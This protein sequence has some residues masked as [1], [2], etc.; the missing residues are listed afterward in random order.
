MDLSFSD[1][2]AMLM[3]A[4][5]TFLERECPA[6][7]VRALQEDGGR[8][9]ASTLWRHLADD[10][11]LG[12]AFPEDVGG[13]GGTLADLGLFYEA[14]GRVLLP[15]AFAATIH[16]GLVVEALGT[17]EQRAEHLGAIATGRCVAAV[18][19]AELEAHHDPAHYRTRAQRHDGG[20][21][22]SGQK[23][24]VPNGQSADLLLVVARA[25]AAEPPAATTV[26]VVPAGTPGVTTSPLA[27]FAKDP[28][29]I[30]NFEA[31]KLGLDAALGGPGGIGQAGPGLAGV[32]DA[33]TALQA[34]E[35]VGGA[36]QVLRMTVAYVSER[37]QFGVPIGSFQAVQHH[38]AD[39]AIKVDGAW[40]AALQAVWLVSE[41]QPAVREV[42]IAKSAAN[43]AYVFSTEMAHQLHGGIGYVREYDLHLWSQRAKVTALTF[44][45][46]E[47]HFHRIATAVG[48]SSDLRVKAD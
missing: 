42:S 44:G 32:E 38:L 46:E 47:H 40:L 23:A 30:I 14:A 6:S 19:A 8:E 20:W 29:A 45:T 34:M 16:A 26:F 37:I 10:G 13:G 27:T 4:A 7:L 41:G 1:E 9:Q 18:A 24:F 5:R 36:G 35:M 15:T 21:L 39:V 43:E 31:V 22:L 12:L 48:G 28:Q 3:D 17:A 2:Q 11:W 33:V 25:E